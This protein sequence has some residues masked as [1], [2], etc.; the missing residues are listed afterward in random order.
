MMRSFF[1]ILVVPGCMGMGIFSLFLNEGGNSVRGIK[2]SEE[3]CQ[4]FGLHLFNC[5]NGK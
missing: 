5:Q 3:L 1:K 4:R 2:V